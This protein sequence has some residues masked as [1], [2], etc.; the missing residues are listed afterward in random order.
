MDQARSLIR[1]VN[2]TTWWQMIR[3]KSKP[4]EWGPGSQR[5]DCIWKELLASSRAKVET[6]HE[7][8]QDHTPFRSKYILCNESN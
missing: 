4:Q 7:Y 2:Y 3:S 1:P 8:E 6:E 5:E